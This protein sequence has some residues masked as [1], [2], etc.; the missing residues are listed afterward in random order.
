[1]DEIVFVHPPQAAMPEGSV[2]PGLFERLAR[3]VM[4]TL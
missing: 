1:M 4:P 3:E 2:E